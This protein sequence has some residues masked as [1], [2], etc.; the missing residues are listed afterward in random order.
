MEFYFYGVEADVHFVSDS[1]C[2]RPLLVSART[3][4]IQR[5]NEGEGKF[6]KT[7]ISFEDEDVQ[8]RWRNL[9]KKT[10]EHFLAALREEAARNPSAKEVA[11]LLQLIERGL[12]I[13]ESDIDEARALYGEGVNQSDFDRNPIRLLWASAAGM[14]RLLIGIEPY[15]A[16]RDR[17]KRL[18]AMVN[19]AKQA[20]AATSA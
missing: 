5:V 17:W 6:L 15:V 1:L 2:V 18:I 3:F 13:P 11:R 9:C 20:E 10:G 19:R 7:H 4:A 16:A 8:E 14:R 12:A